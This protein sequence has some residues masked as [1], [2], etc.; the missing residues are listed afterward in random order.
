LLEHGA[1]AAISDSDGQNTLHLL[2]FS[3][4]RP[5][6]IVLLDILI[7]HGANANYTDKDRNTPL[8][9]MAMNLWQAHTVRFLYSRGADISIININSD[10]VFHKAAEGIILP[11]RTLEVKY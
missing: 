4:A 9:N 5:I 10:T 11:Y 8:H 2:A 1:Y 7:A 6:S 3:K